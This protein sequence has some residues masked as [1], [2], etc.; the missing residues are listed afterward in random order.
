MERREATSTT[1]MSDVEAGRDE[2]ES[3]IRDTARDARYRVKRTV[4]EARAQIGTAYEKSAQA[5]NR[6]YQSAMEYSRENP[7]TATLV[8][9]GAGFG[10]GILFGSQFG[11]RGRGEILPVIATA[12]ADAVLDVFDRR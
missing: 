9:L 8:A 7:G 2:M 1:G 6:A 5:A 12:V 10:L 4:Q 3:E 11:R